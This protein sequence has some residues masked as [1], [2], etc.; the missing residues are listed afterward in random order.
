M[1]KR[2]KIDKKTV[3]LAPSRIRRD[4]ARTSSPEEAAKE[5]RWQ[6]S[7]WEIKLALIGIA[8]FALAINI[9]VLGFSAITGD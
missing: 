8:L 3:E 7:E 2:S 1:I 5:L 9:V 6:S 4:P